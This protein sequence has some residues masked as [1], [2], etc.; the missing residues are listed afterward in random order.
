[1]IF[2]SVPVIL[3]PNTAKSSA[4]M[5]EDLSSFSLGL[6]VK[7]LPNNPERFSVYNM[8][9]GSEGFTSGS[10]SWEVEVGQS[11]HWMV[12]VAQQSVQR[13]GRFAAGPMEG[14]WAVSLRDGS[15]S[16]SLNAAA[17]QKVRVEVN[18]E[19]GRVTFTNTDINKLLYTYT[20]RFTERLFPFFCTSSR[21]P[22]RV[23]PDEVRLKVE[24]HR[25]VVCPITAELEQM[26]L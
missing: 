6:Q 25:A 20:H 21:R 9:L 4:S 23:L 12:G 3:D 7:N 13:K 26:S 16:W 1:M 14:F 17:P 18:W 19:K 22:L 15:Y 10:H 5:S 11:E 24:N 2:I 8:V